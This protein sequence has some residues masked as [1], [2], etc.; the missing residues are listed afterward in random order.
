M[1]GSTT[2]LAVQEARRGVINSSH[3]LKTSLDSLNLSYRNGPFESVIVNDEY[4]WENYGIPTL[5]FSRFPYSEY[6]SSLDSVD[7]MQEQSL[8]EAVAALLGM[9][10]RLEA[11]PIILKKFQGNMC[12]SNPK[13]D[14]YADYGQIAL[15]DTLTEKKRKLRSLMDLVPGLD[16]PTSVRAVANQVG[17]PEADALEYLQRW[18]AKG[19]IE[20]F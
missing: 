17:L 9:I 2:P 8:N 14:L 19:L 3:A 13:Y 10:D 1:L 4:L 20:L 5:S 6:H 15:G 7:K 11:S 12:L 18:A 16:S